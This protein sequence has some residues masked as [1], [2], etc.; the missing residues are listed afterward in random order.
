MDPDSETLAAC[1]IDRLYVNDLDGGRRSVFNKS[2]VTTADRYRCN[3]LS[4][5]SDFIVHVMENKAS[6]ITSEL[7]D[8]NKEFI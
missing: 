4:R 7:I 2:R 3:H 5:S 8:N 1:S 6:E